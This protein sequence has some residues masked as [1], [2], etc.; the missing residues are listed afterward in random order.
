MCGTNR[1]FS[2]PPKTAMYRFPI[3]YQAHTNAEKPKTY[4]DGV[5]LYSGVNVYKDAARGVFA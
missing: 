3:K 4:V 1:R 2:P 5:G